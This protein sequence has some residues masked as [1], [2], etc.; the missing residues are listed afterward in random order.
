MKHVLICRRRR[1]SGCAA[2]LL[3]RERGYD[4]TLS[5]ATPPARR[6]LVR[7]RRHD[8][9]QPLRAAGRAGRWSG[10]ACV[11]VRSRAVPFYIRPRLDADLL[12]WGW[13]FCAGRESRARRALAPLLRDLM[14]GQPRAVTRSWPTRLRRR[15]G[16]VKRGLLM[17]CRTRARLSKR[18]RAR[19]A[20]ARDARPPGRGASRP[21][22]RAELE[23][24][25]RAW[26]SRAP[27]TFPLDCHLDAARCSCATLRQLAVERGVERSL[28]NG[29][30][31]AGDASGARVAAVVTSRGRARRGRVRAVR[32]APGRREV[33]RALGLRAAAA[34]RQGLQPDAPTPPQLPRAVLDP[35]R[36]ARRGDADGQ[37]RCASAAP[38]R[39]PASTRSINPARVRGI[40][41]AAAAV[42]S[43]FHAAG[44]R[45]AFGPG[46]AA[47]VLARRPAVHRPLRALR[48]PLRRH[49]P[50][51]D[52]LSL[53]RSP[54]SSWR[55]A[56]RRTA[57][58]RAR[59]A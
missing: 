44:L 30:R 27:C 33:A 49:R 52:G 9:A 4:V 28:G 6:L 54:G 23:S 58:D 36:G 42:L 29:G 40:I 17:L 48:E 8:R 50:C 10:L 15:F 11:D 35:H 12:H 2:R 13:R 7:Q 24:G 16:L 57:A 3:L 45:A 59:S 47:P 55:S 46:R 18:R 34:S 20:V 19:R 37:R 39:S 21:T 1:R 56:L 41:E 53:A 14:L 5:S 26:T 22:R 32:A 51:H 43:R 25:H 31:T 38:W